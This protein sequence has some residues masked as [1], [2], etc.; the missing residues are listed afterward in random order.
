M[1]NRYIRKDP[2]HPIDQQILDKI[3]ELCVVKV[4][5]KGQRQI[6]YRNLHLKFEPGGYLEYI[7]YNFFANQHT[8]RIYPKKGIQN[9]WSLS[10]SWPVYDRTPKEL[11]K[12]LLKVEDAQRTF[13]E[14]M[15]QIMEKLCHSAEKEILKQKQKISKIQNEISV[16][17]K[18]SL[19]EKKILEDFKNAEH[20]TS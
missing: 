15:D 7:S 1:S 9:S 16:L 6:Y 19:I 12:N 8:I 14:G 18:A 13:I 2:L 20:K 10:F 17:E 5:K 3:L 4:D 11:S